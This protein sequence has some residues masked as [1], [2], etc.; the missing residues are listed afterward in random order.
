MK[1]IANVLAAL[2]IVVGVYYG[3]FSVQ[4]PPGDLK[5]SAVSR[6]SSSITVQTSSEP[7]QENYAWGQLQDI[8]RSCKAY[9]E[10]NG[11]PC[12]LEDIDEL[13]YLYQEIPVDRTPEEGFVEVE[14]VS[15]DLEDF[16]A[17]AR[18]EN[19]DIVWTIDADG[20]TTCSLGSADA[21]WNASHLSRK[22]VMDEVKSVFGD[23]V[24][25][26]ARSMEIKGTFEEPYVE[27]R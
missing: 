1:K 22:E 27:F 26:N 13:P 24:P 7:W 20:I 16:E 17:T 2:A 14:L 21:C 11:T 10:Q 12:T 23:D 15:G 19:S 8:Y 25:D 4:K 5:P 18:H 3:N 9:W 6:S